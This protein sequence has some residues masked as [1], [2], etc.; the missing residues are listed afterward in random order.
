M[1]LLGQII[2]WIIQVVGDLGYPGIFVMMLL[3]SSFFPFPSEVV[4][5]PAGYLAYRGEMSMTIA[6][7]MGIAG[8]LAGALINYYLAVWL[9]RPLLERYGRYLFLPPDKLHRM[10]AFFRDHG[11]ISTFVGRL[12]TVVRQYISFPA[13]LARMP[14]G[15]FLLY[16][17][18][19]AGLWVA[20]LAGIGYLAAGNEA[21]IRAYSREATLA[22]LAFCAVAVGVYV[23]RHRRRTRTQG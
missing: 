22:L 18:L 13:G 1:H 23:A 8:S 10:E 4:M 7:A 15:R 14:M 5:I 3:E 12:I 16:T 2:D 9:G 11:E 17:G 19:G 21:L 6:I 20:I